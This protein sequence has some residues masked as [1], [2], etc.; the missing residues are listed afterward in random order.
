MARIIELRDGFNR[1]EEHVRGWLSEPERGSGSVTR[2]ERQ[3]GAESTRVDRDNW[4]KLQGVLPS[5]ETCEVLLEYYIQ[6]VKSHRHLLFF[7]LV[8]DM[9]EDKS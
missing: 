8:K 3:S 1:L 4:R 7:F 6:E 5:R 9:H 2:D